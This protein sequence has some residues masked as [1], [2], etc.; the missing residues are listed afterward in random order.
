VLH[1][2]TDRS[3]IAPYSNIDGAFPV[4]ALVLYGGTLYGTTYFGGNWGNGSVFQ[5]NSDGTGFTSLYSFSA[6][7]TSPPYGNFDGAFPNAGLIISNNSLYGTASA[8]GL[9]NNGTVFNVNTDGAGFSTI[10]SFSALNTNNANG[11]GAEPLAVLTLSGSTL[12]GTAFHGG[13]AGIGTVFRVNT[14]GTAFASLRG[15]SGNDGALPETGLILANNILYGTGSFGGGGLNGTVFSF[16]LTPELS[17]LWIPAGPHIRLL[18]STNAIGY[19][20]QSSPILFSTTWTNVSPTPVIANGQ[21]A[22]T[23]S[24]LGPQ[25][26]YRLSQ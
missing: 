20:L 11:D 12:Y 9:W 21:N 4:G 26:F 16:S 24:V 18:W 1:S 22:V 19:N 17:M 7:A 14:D 15:L 10:H 2:F 23:K 6:L 3:P 5:V 8:G 13:A 25:L